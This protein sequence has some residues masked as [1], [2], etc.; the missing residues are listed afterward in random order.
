MFNA[1]H[2]VVSETVEFFILAAAGT[3]SPTKATI[4]K[5][6]SFKFALE[7]GCTVVGRNEISLMLLCCLSGYRI[8]QRSVERFARQDLAIVVSDNVAL[9]NA[10][11]TIRVKG[12]S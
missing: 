2:G 11:L 5:H 7:Q 3:S 12:S 6:V 1:L 4:F 10:G 8:Q 9:Q